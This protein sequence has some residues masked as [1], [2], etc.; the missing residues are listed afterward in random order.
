MHGRTEDPRAPSC[1]CVVGPHDGKGEP[2]TL[3]L[4]DQV[5]FPEPFLRSAFPNL[6]LGFPMSLPWI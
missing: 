4:A 2:L 6:R 3:S 5:V 1:F